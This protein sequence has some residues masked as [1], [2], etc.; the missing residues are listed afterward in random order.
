MTFSKLSTYLE[1]L[2]KTSSRN[3]ITWILAD[4]FKK[5]TPSEID[6]ICYLLLG[7]LV[8][9]YKGIE[10][11]LAEKMMA[12]ILSRG[13][14][15]RLEQVVRMYKKSGDLGDTAVALA[16]NHKSLASRRSGQITNHKLSVS[17][18]YDRLMKIAM[19]SGQGSQERKI[20][21]TARLLGELDPKSTKFVARVPV[22]KLRLG[23]SNATILDALSV[24]ERGD[25]SG[26]P[27]IETA[28]NV[29]ADIGTIAVHVKKGGIKSLSGIH[30]TPGIPIRPSLAERLPTALK[31]IEKVGPEVGIEPKLDGFRTAIHI[32]PPAQRASGPEGKKKNV[33]LFSRNLEN[34]THMF[35]EIIEAAS[36]LPVK[37]AILDGETIGYNPKTGKFLPF[38]ETVQRKRKHGVTEAAKKLPLRTFVFDI[39][40]L[41][42]RD[43]LSL[44]FVKRRE[45]LEKTIK[46]YQDG[47]KLA[48]HTITSDVGVIVREFKKNIDAGLEGIVA[49]KLDAPY[50][51]GGRGFHWIKLKG[52]SGALEKLRGGAKA[53]VL[54][55]IDCVIMGAYRGRGKRASFGVGGF[56]LGVR[57]GQDKY[58]SL[59]RLGT[60]LSDEQFREAH[61]RVTKL[62]AGEKPKEYS[63]AAEEV[64]DI[65][66]KPGVV[67]EIL[68][69][70]ITLS[71]RHTAARR[72]D[73]GLSLRFPRLVRFR[74]DKNP[75][76]ATSAKEVES[77]YK[78]QSKKKM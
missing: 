49:K 10:F 25:K 13:Y 48:E 58:Y 4:L 60:G 62:Q 51:A 29:T 20:L 56:L 59:S 6:K 24:M 14:G 77:M 74:D 23:F 63:V 70:E 75:E 27:Q 67:V 22:G 38:Q 28:Y 76:D 50:E 55:T 21:G 54:D 78:L 40:Y 3:E 9:A 68:A 44:P 42:G 41:D 19:E 32:W 45:I 71:P 30:A 36:K 34:T 69:D 72:G 64:P 17:D 35:P 66:V 73:R 65:W 2:E 7:E 52:G 12:K 43:L 33:A 8:P 31:I 18:V 53:G 57:G 5:T 46:G 26:R 61:R 39:L 15:V 37:S 47:I 11:N 1:K 16:T